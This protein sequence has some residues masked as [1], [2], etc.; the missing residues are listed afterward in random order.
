MQPR[1][2]EDEFWIT[3]RGTRSPIIW[4]A[5]NGNSRGIGLRFFMPRT[6]PQGFSWVTLL[7]HQNPAYGKNQEDM[8][9]EYGGGKPF[10]KL[11]LSIHEFKDMLQRK[12]EILNLY[13]VSVEMELKKRQKEQEEREEEEKIAANR[14][15]HRGEKNNDFEDEDDEP[16]ASQAFE[17]PSFQVP[18][19][20][21]Y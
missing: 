2:S 4:L 18:N 6:E 16:P 19:G 5:D 21:E 9:E 10:R 13:D 14:K 3:D 12:Q 15:R 17:K 7:H 20:Q 11:V 1:I 8:K